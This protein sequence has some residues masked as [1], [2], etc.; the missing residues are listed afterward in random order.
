MRVRSV[1]LFTATPRMSIEPKTGAI[2][3]PSELKACE[4]INLLEAVSGLPSMAT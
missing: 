4:R 1:A 3:V 2:V